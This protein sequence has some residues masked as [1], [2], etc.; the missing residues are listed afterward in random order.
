MVLVVQSCFLDLLGA[1]KIRVK[2]TKVTFDRL[3]EFR[4]VRGCDCVW[5]EFVGFVP[6]AHNH[7][8]MVGVEVVGDGYVHYVVEIFDERNV[9]GVSC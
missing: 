8:K 5:C 3:S 4:L 1:L 9:Q 7:Q 2:L 6:N